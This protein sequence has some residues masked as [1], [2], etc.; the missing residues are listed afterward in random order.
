MKVSELGQ[1]GLID[2][3]A[4]IIAA[5]RDDRAESWQNLLNGIGDD[6]AVW[7]TGAAHQLAKVD[8]QVEGVHFNLDILTWA[9]LGW[10]ALAVNLSDIAAMGGVPLYALV[11][12]GLPP[13]TAVEDVL[14]F[15]RGMLELAQKSG[16]AIVGGNMSGSPFVFIDVSL[17]GRTNPPEGKY[18]SRS[19][20]VPGDRI[21]VTGWLG[22]AAAGLE[23]LRRGLKLGPEKERALKSA[24]CRPEP[25]L[26]EGRLLLENGIRTGIDIS[27]GLLA[28]LG[29]ICAASNVGAVV[30]LAALPIKDAVREAFGERASEIALAGGEDYQLL[31]C[32][33]GNAIENIRRI[34]AY[35]VTVIGEITAE[36]RWRVAVI[37]A[38]GQPVQPARTGWD[39]FKK[40]E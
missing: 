18:L 11:S 2:E 13:A 31:F 16:T 36:N 20:A 34:S 10:K 19:A 29:H 15:Y 26:A 17:I 23:M 12:M 4:K 33:P 6:C 14:A 21:A 32:G 5:A 8:C 7:R 25:R 37:D 30:R 40:K 38:A 24:F 27:D 22:T 9:D 3:V 28:D 1:F 35:P 39:H